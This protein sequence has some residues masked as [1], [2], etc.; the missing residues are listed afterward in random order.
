[1]QMRFWYAITLNTLLPGSV[2]L[3]SIHYQCSLDLTQTIPMGF[4]ALLD[5]FQLIFHHKHMHFQLY[6]WVIIE[7]AWQ[8]LSGSKS[9]KSRPLWPQNKHL[10]QC[11]SL[12]SSMLDQTIVHP[13]SVF[14]LQ[15]GRSGLTKTFYWPLKAPAPHPERITTRVSGAL[16]VHANSEYAFVGT[17]ENCI[18]G[19][20]RTTRHVLTHVHQTHIKTIYV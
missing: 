15:C 12:P 14:I 6:W 17:C 2:H 8:P 9:S 10:Q 3:V 5:M 13:R 19:Y 16:Y 1:M 4:L 18:N 7:A 20:P 11:H